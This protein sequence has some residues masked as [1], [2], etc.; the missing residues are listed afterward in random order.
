MNPPPLRQVWR[1][2]NSRRLARYRGGLSRGFSMI[3]VLVSIV[4]L[5]FGLLGMVGLQ[6]AALKNNRDARLQSTAVGFAREMA[7]MMRA[8]AA[9]GALQTNNPYFGDFSGTGLAP[10]TTSDCLSVGNTCANAMSVANAQMTEWLKRVEAGLPGAR[11]S[12]CLDTA[13]Y[14]SNGLPQWACTAP[15]MTQ[16]NIAYI[17]LGWTRANTQSQLEQAVDS[18]SRPFV[19]LPITPG[20]QL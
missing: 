13:P 10:G 2:T 14:D 17:K 8:N 7:E 5:S 3:E 1:L 19:V 16:Q 11:V 12:I 18:G 9:V 4:V 20:G 15:T 6:A